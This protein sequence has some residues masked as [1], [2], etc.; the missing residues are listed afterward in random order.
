MPGELNQTEY[1]RISE[2]PYRPNGDGKV[3]IAEF[4]SSFTRNVRWVLVLGCS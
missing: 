4:V 2:H 3:Y 1:R